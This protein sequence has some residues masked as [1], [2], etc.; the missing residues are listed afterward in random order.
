MKRTTCLAYFGA[1]LLFSR[2]SLGCVTTV[3]A[4]EGSDFDDEVADVALAEPVLAQL[5]V[6]SPGRDAVIARW[7]LP[8]SS[9]WLPYEKLTLPTVLSDKAQI[10]LLPEVEC[11][12]E[13]QVAR[14]AAARIAGD[15]VP[16]GTAW[17]VDLSGAASV[18]FAQT[19]A[20][21]SAAPIAA[22]PTFNNWPAEDE[23]IPAEET[24]T[25]M[26]T[27][28]PHLPGD[29][30]V[31]AVPVFLLDSWRL[32]YKDEAIGEGAVDNRYM[33]TPGD[34]PS[35][36]VLR[37]Q[38]IT[39]IIYLVASDEIEGEDDDLNELFASYEDAGITLHLA[40][41]DTIVRERE[42]WEEGWSLQIRSR[43]FHVRRRRTVVHSPAFY[44]LSPGG[45]GGAHM[46]PSPS[47]HMYMG[48]H[49]GG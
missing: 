24:L 46:V 29:D 23:V 9:P 22:I 6:S 28:P 4:P 10:L 45:F 11:L 7:Q 27:S 32:A 49:G 18:A 1:V 3:T 13:V 2:A 12:E 34:F 36:G 37:A 26:I 42:D 44:H 17:F 31:G 47:G 16:N 20:R 43:V 39:E 35:P 33:L 30:D 48:F 41:L 19:L 8:P 15:G 25:A 14:S 5:A 40:C 21:Y 38:G